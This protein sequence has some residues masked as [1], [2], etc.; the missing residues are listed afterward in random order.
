[1]DRIGNALAAL[2][3]EKQG[4]TADGQDKDYYSPAL[5][6]CATRVHKSFNR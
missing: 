5:P 2:Q 6:L 4:G 1:M 3:V